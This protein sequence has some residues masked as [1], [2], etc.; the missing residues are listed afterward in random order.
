MKKISNLE[1]VNQLKLDVN[2]L[3]PA[4][5][6]DY[7]DNKVLMVA[8]MDKESLLK[9]IETGKTW[10]YSRSRKKLWMKGEESGNI[11]IVKDILVDCDND[12]LVIKVK[13]VG[14]ASCHT[15]YRSCFYRKFVNGK[16]KIVE[17]KIFEPEKV[18][19]K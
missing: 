8:Y 17:E 19:K 13:Q 5:I 11:Q 12:C 2:G 6:Q 10:F 9:T 3:I 16:F 1:F 15:G 14:K 4:I 7:K 18:Y